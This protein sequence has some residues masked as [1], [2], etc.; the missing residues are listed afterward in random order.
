[1]RRVPQIPHFLHFAGE[2]PERSKHRKNPP[3]KPRDLDAAAKVV[4]GIGEERTDLHVGMTG[5]DMDR[6]GI[7]D[8]VEG[9][10]DVDGDSL[11]NYSDT[12]AD[13]DGIADAIEGLSD[14]DGDGLPAYLD[15]D[16]T[17]SM[18]NRVYLPVI[19]R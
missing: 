5:E 10:D 16:E 11:P 8:D 9:A 15:S 1:M 13:G 3:W 7:S 4:L 19:R 14:R 18:L 6:D 17:V 12:D 2:L